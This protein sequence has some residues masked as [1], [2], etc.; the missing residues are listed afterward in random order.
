MKKQVKP[1][2]PQPRVEPDCAYVIPPTGTCP[3]C[4]TITK[5]DELSQ[6][7]KEN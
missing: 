6:R 4:T 3:S 1:T 7:R 2:R 5:P